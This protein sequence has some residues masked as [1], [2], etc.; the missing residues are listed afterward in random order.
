MAKGRDSR[1]CGF[2]G[3]RSQSRRRS[4]FAFFFDF[5]PSRFPLDFLFP[6]HR[7]EQTALKPPR[8]PP[9]RLFRKGCHIQADPPHTILV[10]INVRVCDVAL[11]WDLHLLPTPIGLMWPS[12]VIVV[13]AEG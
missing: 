7:A 2:F 12:F 6:A 11:L 3:F 4:T 8:A 10:L 5:I 1:D 13:K 9:K